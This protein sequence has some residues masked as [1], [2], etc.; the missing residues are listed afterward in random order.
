MIGMAKDVSALRREVAERR[1][2]EVVRE[3]LRRRSQTP[4]ESLRVLSGHNEGLRRF[5]KESR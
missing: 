5:R 4:L 2:R 1:L 3:A